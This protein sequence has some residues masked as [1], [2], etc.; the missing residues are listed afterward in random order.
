M[1]GFRASLFIGLVAGCAVALVASPG[2][3]A[4]PLLA[5]QAASTCTSCHA[6]PDR[7]DP[8]WVESN[9]RL[10]AR[11]CRAT[12]GSCHVNPDGGMLRTAAGQHFGVRSLPL[13]PGRAAPLEQGLSLIKDNPLLTFGGD[14]RL[15]DIFHTGQQDKKSPHFFPM[16]ADIYLGSRLADHLSLLTQFGLQRGGN[17]VFRE[18]FGMVDN[19]PYNGHLKFGKFLPPFGHRLDD[20]T[21]YI[22]KELFV[23][24]SS[25]VSYGSGVEIGINPLVAYA[26]LAY[27]NEDIAPASNSDATST[28]ASGVLGWQ[29]LWLQLGGSYLRVTDNRTWGFATGLDAETRGD[30]TA[31]GGYGSVNLWRLTWLFEFDLVRNDLAGGGRD[32]DEF[33]TFNELNLLVAKGT[34]LKARYE[35]L[36]PDRDL[37]DDEW[38]RS[39]VGLEFHPWPFVELDAQYRYN[40]T[41]TENYGQVLLLV[42]LWY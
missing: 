25:P 26:R 18:V 38:S 21:A 13:F 31:Y 4:T 33:I 42:H 28:I 23:D 34:T 15:L 1:S 32:F 6:A 8:K 3:R 29:G 27:L 10:A 17:P 2:A 24:Q 36:D 9:Y 30:R 14:F 7:A 22:R 40:D 16:Q 5:M 11:R 39:L 20:H 12:C 35:T 41:P 37:P 19:L